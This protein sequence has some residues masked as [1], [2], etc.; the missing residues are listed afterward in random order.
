MCAVPLFS[1]LPL[2]ALRVRNPDSGLTL[3]KELV[4]FLLEHNS[5]GKSLTLFYFFLSFFSFFLGGG[6]KGIGFKML[7]SCW[8]YSPDDKKRAIHYKR[9]AEPRRCLAWQES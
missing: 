3:S 7:D 6:I 5:G 8:G 2:S 9:V 4:T 1:A